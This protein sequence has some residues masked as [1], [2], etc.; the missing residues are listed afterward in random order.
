MKCRRFSSNMLKAWYTSHI[1]CFVG[2]YRSHSWKRILY[3]LRLQERCEFSLFVSCINLVQA[4]FGNA[5]NVL[6][7]FFQNTHFFTN[8]NGSFLHK[9][10]AERHGAPKGKYFRKPNGRGARIIGGWETFS[11]ITDFRRQSVL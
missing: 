1:V 8:S 3:L 5:L 9:L 4:N 11:P 2:L 6:I 7:F 10:I